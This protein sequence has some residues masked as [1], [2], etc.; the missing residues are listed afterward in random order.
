[1]EAAPVK[2][3]TTPPAHR[4]RRYGLTPED[5]STLLASQGYKCPLCLKPFGPARSPQTD[6]DHRTGHTRG[7]LCVHCNNQVL[8]ITDDVDYWHRLVR[9]LESP[10]AARLPGPRRAALTYD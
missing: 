4:L 7:L 5:W 2:P 8:G 9:Y 6:H 3:P 1:V 10:P